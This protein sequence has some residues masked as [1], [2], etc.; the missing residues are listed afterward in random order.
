MRPSRDSTLR[1]QTGRS[2]L[3][4][5][6]I[7]RLLEHFVA[8]TP[9][10]TAAE[11]IGIHRNSATRFFHRLRE[12]IAVRLDNSDPSGSKSALEIEIGVHVFGGSGM[13]RPARGAAGNVTVIGLLRRGSCIYTVVLADARRD[14]LVSILRDRLDAGAVVYADRPAVHE[15]LDA[16]GVRHHRI[17]RCAPRAGRRAHISGIENYWSQTE[18]HLRRYNGIPTHRFALFLKE[19]EWRF[20]YGSPN[21][22]LATLTE[23]IDS[24]T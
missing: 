22:L 24:S 23:W 2:R 15:A 4:A 12:V 11:L 19:C 18:R 21:Q 20:N 17:D 8:G 9:A 14:T 5:G 16:L 1:Q 3:S 6:Q 10:R 13:L 7:R